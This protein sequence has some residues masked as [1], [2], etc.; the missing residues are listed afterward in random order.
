MT[1][2]KMPNPAKIEKKIL[3]R[4]IHLSGANKLFS[5]KI[6]HE[7]DA[8]REIISGILSRLLCMRKNPTAAGTTTKQ[9]ATRKYA[10]RF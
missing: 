4:I 9:L 3:V 8:A 6:S 7:N 10:R 5:E 2:Y 1:R